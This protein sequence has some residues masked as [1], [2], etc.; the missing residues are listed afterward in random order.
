MMHDTR[1]TRAELIREVTRLRARVDELESAAVEPESARDGRFPQG[2]EGEYGCVFNFI[3][4]AIV[5]FDAKTLEFLDVND[6]A[7][8]LYGYTRRE[9][10]RLRKADILAGPEIRDVPTERAGKRE[11]SRI[12]LCYHRKK[13]GTVFPVEVTACPL[14]FAGRQVICLVARDVT[15]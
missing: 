15:K 2:T 7:L 8:G 14:I 11:K 9:F 13:D 6:A 4:D 3:P 5:L 10:L 1:K 12:P